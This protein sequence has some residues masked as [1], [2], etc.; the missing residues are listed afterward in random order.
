M[1]ARD[2]LTDMAK[3]DIEVRAEGGHLRIIGEITDHDREQ[4]CLH[5]SELLQHLAANDSTVW[6]N[7]SDTLPDTCPECHHNIWWRD[8]ASAWHCCRCDPR[9]DR[10]HT[11]LLA[12]PPADSDTCTPR[13]ES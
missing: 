12:C 8:T 10:P 1:N 11:E 6:E 7:F 13:A 4:L 9:G 2:L 3:R 5:K